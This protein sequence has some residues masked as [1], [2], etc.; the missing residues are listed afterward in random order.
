MNSF[1]ITCLITIKYK[2]TD[3]FCINNDDGGHVKPRKAD[4]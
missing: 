1:L 2:V 4:A 3:T